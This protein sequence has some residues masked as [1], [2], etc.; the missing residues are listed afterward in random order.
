[1][2]K[3]IIV[4]AVLCLCAGCTIHFKATDV[5]LDAERQRVQKNATYELDSVS[6]LYGEAG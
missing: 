2:K 4:L 3:L 1:M 6:V 5:E